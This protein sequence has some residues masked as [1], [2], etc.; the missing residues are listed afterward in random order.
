MTDRKLTTG[1]PASY[2]CSVY[3]TPKSS[4]GWP[5]SDFFRF[6]WIK[7]NFNRIKSTTKF[8]MLSQRDLYFIFT[9]CSIRCIQVY[10]KLHTDNTRNT[11]DLATTYSTPSPQEIRH[12]QTLGTHKSLEIK[13]LNRITINFFACSCKNITCNS[14]FEKCCF[15]CSWCSTCRS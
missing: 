14:K 13:I 9:F 5:K 12:V 2:R 7:V 4:K 8:G 6:F 3:V 11:T 15:L 1:F 10:F